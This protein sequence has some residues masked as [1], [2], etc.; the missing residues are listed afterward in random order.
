M[1]KIDGRKLHEHKLLELRE[2]AF[3][4]MDKGISNKEIAQNLGLHEVTISKWKKKGL[5][6]TPKGR[7]TGEKKLLDR[8]ME[9]KVYSNLFDLSP[10]EFDTSFIFWTKKLIL[11][12]I[13]KKFKKD[14]ASSTLGDY[15][16]RW[17]LN[18]DDVQKFKSK[19]IED[20]ENETYIEMKNKAKKSYANIWWVHICKN[21]MNERNGH[22]YQFIINNNTGLLMLDLYKSSDLKENFKNFLSKSTSSTKKRFFLIVNGLAENQYNELNLYISKN[23]QNQI[24]EFIP[25]NL[26]N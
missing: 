16:K 15:L 7:K 17:S 20:I 8:S 3:R 21:S 11:K 25:A 5:K 6:I 12:M 18:S 14:I 1:K 24:L 4:L 2:Q 19:F 9:Q 23:Y 10:I 13:K 26:I 22:F